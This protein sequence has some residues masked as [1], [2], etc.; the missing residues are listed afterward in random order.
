MQE[1][2]HDLTK[3]EKKDIMRD[4][5]V[6]ILP[7]FKKP[8]EE[9]IQSIEDLANFYMEQLMFQLNNYGFNVMEEKFQADINLV[10][11]F[12]KTA[13][14]RSKNHEHNLGIVIEDLH[15]MVQ[16]SMEI[17][18]EKLVRKNTSKVANKNTIKK[19]LL[20]AILA[21]TDADGNIKKD[22]VVEALAN[23]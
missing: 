20:T 13:L 10:T 12:L 21:N 1:E 15:N 18:R 16:E 9:E 23:I 11:L 14:Y 7:F 3:E 19:K 17:E 2:Y 6:I 5:N 8:K 22:L 4:N